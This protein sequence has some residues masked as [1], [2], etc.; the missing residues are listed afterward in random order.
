MLALADVALTVSSA[1]TSSKWWKEKLGFAVHHVGGNAH[2]IMVAPPGDKFVLHLCEGFGAL[3]PGNTGIAFMTDEID[4]L[5][6]RLQAEGVRF[7]EPIQRSPR[8]ASTKFEDL[9]GNVFTLVGA[10]PAF[11]RGEAERKAPDGAPRNP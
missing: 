3:E 7:T 2:A 1:E 6:A 11:V 9:D 4:A 10:P 5:V 8:G